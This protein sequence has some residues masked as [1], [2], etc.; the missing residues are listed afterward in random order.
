MAILTA[1]LTG[2]AMQKPRQKTPYNLWGPANCVFV[3]PV[4]NKRV[5]QDSIPARQHAVLRSSIYKELFNKLPVDKRQEWI[6]KAER[7]HS[8]ALKKF[9]QTLNSRPSTAPADQQRYVPYL[10]VEI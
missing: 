4:F 6:E 8:D 2:G 9:N 5:Q 7:E 10:M 1:Q 3:D